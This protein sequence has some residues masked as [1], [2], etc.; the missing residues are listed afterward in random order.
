MGERELAWRSRLAVFKSKLRIRHHR[1]GARTN[2]SDLTSA[3]MHPSWGWPV[4]AVQLFAHLGDLT[5]D[6]VAIPSVG[7][8][9]RA[10]RDDNSY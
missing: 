8:G 10:N 3:A 6:S 7:M 5:V 4:I 9:A 2:F 1:S